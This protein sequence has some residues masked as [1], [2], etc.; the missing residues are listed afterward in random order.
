MLLLLPQRYEFS[1][2]SQPAT[3]QHQPT[4]RCCCY[5]KG[6]NFQANHNILYNL[7]KSFQL[8]LLPQRYEFSSKSQP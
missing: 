3:S 7:N 1:S 6:T 5:R 2:K 4:A 8:L